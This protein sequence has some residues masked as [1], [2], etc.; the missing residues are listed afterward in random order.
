MRILLISLLVLA[1]APILYCEQEQQKNQTTVL[2]PILVYP[3]ELLDPLPQIQAPDP[4]KKEE[5]IEV[6]SEAYPGLNLDLPQLN[7]MIGIQKYQVYPPFHSA[8]YYEMGG[9]PVLSYYG[10]TTPSGQLF[11]TPVPTGSEKKEKE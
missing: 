5:Y 8:Q 4:S 10:V 9:N 6:E 1:F 11:S 2:T 7:D 3:K